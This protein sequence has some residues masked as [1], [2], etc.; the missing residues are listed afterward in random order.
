M[1]RLPQDVFLELI[2]IKSFT[3]DQLQQEE[4]YLEDFIRANPEP[5]ELIGLVHLN[6][7]EE[8]A[9]LSSHANVS[10]IPDV[11]DDGALDSA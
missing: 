1:L 8:S 6:L 7:K 11:A 2:R 5:I 3:A 10:D 4:Q 9:K